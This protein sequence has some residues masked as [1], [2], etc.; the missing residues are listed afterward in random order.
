MTKI[1]ATMLMLPKMPEMACSTPTDSPAMAVTAA[2]T[3]MV[4]S[5]LV[6]VR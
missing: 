3:S 1:H 2:D 4:K 6:A 5:T